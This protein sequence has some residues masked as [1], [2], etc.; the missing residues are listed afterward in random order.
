MGV[1][2]ESSVTDTC[3]LVSCFVPLRG[4]TVKRSERRTTVKSQ[5]SKAKVDTGLRFLSC[6]L[7]CAGQ[8]RAH[9][10]CL[11][12]IVEVLVGFLGKETGN[13][14]GRKRMIPQSVRSA[15]YSQCDNGLRNEGA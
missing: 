4:H 10:D 7:C 8:I 15:V 3:F 14:A 1:P 13:V 6:S 5:R 11:F 12:Q 2:G 9:E